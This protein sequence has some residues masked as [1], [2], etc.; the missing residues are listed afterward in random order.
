MHHYP[1]N[2]YAQTSPIGYNPERIITCYIVNSTRY[3][4]KLYSS[5]GGFGGFLDSNKMHI[6]DPYQSSISYINH[7]SS[8][9]FYTYPTLIREDAKFNRIDRTLGYEMIQKDVRFII[10]IDYSDYHGDKHSSPDYDVFAGNTNTIPKGVIYVSQS[11]KSQ[12][13]VSVGGM[14]LKELH[15]VITPI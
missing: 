10:N 7:G 5:S 11:K 1:Y 3:D 6:Q 13:D 12:F 2:Y 9:K 15:Y 14:F 4:F 8:I